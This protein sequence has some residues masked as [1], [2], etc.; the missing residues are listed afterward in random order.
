MLKKLCAF[1]LVLTIVLTGCGGNVYRN[2]TVEFQSPNDD[3][4]K[5]A[6]HLNVPMDVKLVSEDDAD[7]ATP[8]KT[9]IYRKENVVGSIV[10]VASEP[11]L[12]CKS[13]TDV[14]DQIT[15]EWGFLKEE[16]IARKELKVSTLKASNANFGI[17]LS[18]DKL[19][20]YIALTIQEDQFTQDEINM[21][22]G[23][24]VVT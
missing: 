21:L 13:T 12:T 3:S 4:V 11:Y 18:S 9:F 2:K 16:D 14:L 1:A 7:A 8:Q 19:G 10:F 20:L 15:A 22:E 5:L 24:L 17:L 23:S 6:L